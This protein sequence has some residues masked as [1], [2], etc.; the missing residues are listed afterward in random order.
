MSLTDIGHKILA[1]FNLVI[2][3][4]KTAN[5]NLEGV[6]ERAI[7]N[8]YERFDLW[9][10]NLGLYQTGHDSLDY[11]LRD[12]EAIRTYTERLLLELHRSVQC[13]KAP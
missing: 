1:L 8:E 10:I 13:G 12:A 9:A 2:L 3:R 4:L 5:A 6:E 7:N 11:R